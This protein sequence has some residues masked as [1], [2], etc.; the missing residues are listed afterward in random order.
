MQPA[1]TTPKTTLK[2]VIPL[3]VPAV[4]VSDFIEEEETPDT[5]IKSGPTSTITVSGIASTL[6]PE[7]PKI[8]NEEQAKD[9]RV[10]RTKSPSKYQAKRKK[11]V[12]ASSSTSDLETTFRFILDS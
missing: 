3:S 7:T 1:Q 11:D 12:Q 8:T 2:A 6:L 4:N 10:T 5:P 9:N